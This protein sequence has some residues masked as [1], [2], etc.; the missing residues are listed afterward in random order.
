MNSLF[1][2]YF[3]SLLLPL[4]CYSSCS[5]KTP[6]VDRGEQTDTIAVKCYVIAQHIS[7]NDLVSKSVR[8]EMQKSYPLVGDTIALEF[9]NDMEALSESTGM[10]PVTTSSYKKVQ[11]P[12][13][14]P[15]YYIEVFSKT[16]DTKGIF[17]ESDKKYDLYVDPST[18]RFH[19]L[20]YRENVMIS[21]IVEDYL[22]VSSFKERIDRIM[23]SSSI[24][25]S[26][27]RER[28]SKASP[29]VDITD[30]TIASAIDKG[31]ILSVSLINPFGEGQTERIRNYS[32][33]GQIDSISKSQ[34]KRIRNLL[35]SADSYKISN[36]VVNATFLPD[37]AISMDYQGQRID[38]LFSLYSDV[39]KLFDNEHEFTLDISP[40]KQ[41][42]VSVFID[43][44]PN[45][46]FIKKYKNE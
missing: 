3:C 36:V 9:L 8:Y 21:P 10:T 6:L 45:D 31:Q 18:C 43:L 22:V 23:N 42:W 27:P 13:Y 19:F 38:A 41:K 24:P 11:S 46:E 32:I 33:V 15:Q 39:M 7:L 5:A 14:S 37:V 40:S 34:Q 12:D 2:K 16:G 1:V 29:I 35:S 4:F 25:E 44:F 26:D 17:T 28:I 20:S 30:T